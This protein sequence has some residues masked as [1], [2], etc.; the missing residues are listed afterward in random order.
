MARGLPKSYIVRARRMLPKGASISQI[1]KKAW[2][3]YK[4]S[5]VYKPLTRKVKNPKKRGKTRM[6][7][8]KRRSRRYSMTIPIA[9]IVGLAVGMAKPLD[10]AIKGNIPAAVDQLKYNY[11]GL[12]VDNKFSTTGLMQGLVPLVAGLLVHKFVGGAPLNFNKM[13][14][15]AR[16]PFIRI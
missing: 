16:V 5:K 13:L 7:R 8:R 14:A 6:A 3:L 12:T 2:R 1:F 11:L 9:P 10:N 15:R 4:G